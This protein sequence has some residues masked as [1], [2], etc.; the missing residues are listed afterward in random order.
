MVVATEVVEKEEK[1]VNLE[2]P[3]NLE[4]SESPEEIETRETIEN[5]NS[6]SNEAAVSSWMSR[7]ESWTKKFEKNNVDKNK[8]QP[9]NQIVEEKVFQK[10]KSQQ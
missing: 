10:D 4:E 8:P 5:R 6:A 7:F 9:Q 3:D 1:P 2:E